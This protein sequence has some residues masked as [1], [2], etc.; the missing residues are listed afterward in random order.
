MPELLSRLRDWLRRDRLDAELQEELRFHRQQLARDGHDARRGLGNTTIVIEDA[1]SRWSVPWLDHF[2][3]D[4]RYALRGLRRSPG[5]TLGVVATLGLGIGANAA[6]FGVIDRLMFRPYPFLEEPETV[7]RVYRRANQRFREQFGTSFEYTRYLDFK[8]STTTLSQYAAFFAYNQAVGVGEAARE[9][10]VA[11]VSAE[12]FAFFDARPALGR[13]F[14]ASEDTTP[15]GANVAVLDHD[16][17][18]AEFGGR[19]VIGEPLQ[20]RNI[21]TT[22]IGV[23]PKGFRGVNEDAPPAVY[24]PITTFAGNESG[25]DRTTYYTTYDWGWMEMMVRRKP[26]VTLA[27]ASSDLTNALVQSWNAEYARDPQSVAPV[28]VARPQVVLGPLKEAAGPDPGLEARTMLWVTGVAIIVLMIACANVANLF[29]ARS[30]RRRREVALRLALGVSRGRLAL[31]ALTESLVLSLL[32]CAVGMVVAQWGG[33]AL[34]RLFLRNVSSFDLLTDGRT[35]GVAIGAALLAGLVTGVAPLLFARRS[36]VGGALKAGMREG[37]YQRSRLRTGL[38]VAQGALS[39]VL[40]VGA[41]LFVR[42]LDRVENKRIGFDTDRVLFVSRQ[43][44]GA[45]IEPGDYIALRRRLLEAAQALPEVEAAAW[46]H[47][48]PFWST[49][50]TRLY[51]PGIDSVRR[52]GHFTYQTATADYFRAMGTRIMRGRGFTEADREGAPLVAVVSESMARVLW[53]GRD[54]LGQCMRVGSDTV[55]C[56]TVVGIAEDVV[57]NSLIDDPKLRYY[58]SIDQF[59]PESGIGLL[60][61]MRGDPALAAEGVRRALLPVMPPPTYLNV[62]PLR[63]IVDSQRRSWRVGATMFVA[64]GVLALVVA[65]VGLYGV[66]AYN[67]TQRMHE[68][69]VRIALGARSPDVVRLVVGHGVRVALVGIGVGLVIAL[70]VARWVEPLLFEQSAKDPIVFGAVGAILLLVALV[71]SGV[72]ALRAARAD[73]NSVLRSE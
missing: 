10:L 7:H 52:L 61:R 17:W 55:P 37:T 68:L 64:F 27:E 43:M 32:G 13:Y 65:A 42:S 59:R 23:A 4:V 16:F 46:V 69:G 40:L 49:S 54:A 73:P 51:V 29:L 45:T 28:D 3:Q 53:P 66:L 12:F 31:Q 47:S 71:A 5:F 36:D 35:L 18:L 26:G 2:Q 48:V 72:P 39:V 24:I 62:R 22:I 50:S 6:M 1:R 20:V 60:L 33:M 11:A 8:R 14:V 9:R 41:G 44:R 15:V 25:E 56:S 58:V 19:N 38:L 63:E 34:R 70:S 21:P 67:V 30:L 57:Q